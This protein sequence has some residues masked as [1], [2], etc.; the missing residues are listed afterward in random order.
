[1]YPSMDTD[2]VYLIEH[3]RKPKSTGTTMLMMVG[4]VLLML[5]CPALFFFGRGN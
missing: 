4:G 1:M 3:N 2:S 5:A